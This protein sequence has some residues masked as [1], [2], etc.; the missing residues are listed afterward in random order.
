MALEDDIRAKAVNTFTDLW[1]QRTGIVVPDGRTITQGNDFIELPRATVAYADLDQ[2]TALVDAKPWWFAAEVY[3]TFLY[4]AARIFRAEGGTI[5]SYDGD[6]VMAI[7]LGAD[8]CVNAVKA[9]MKLNKAVK[10]VIQPAL[11]QRYADK[12]PYQIRHTVGIDV[13][14]IRAAQAGTRGDNDLVWVGRAANHAAKLNARSS[15]LA[16][17]VTRDVYVALD[18]STWY[19]NGI[20]TGTIMWMAHDAPEVPGGKAYGSNYHWVKI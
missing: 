8:Q 9:A 5:T 10:L 14:T 1:P 7:F 4:A 18:N 11:T 17:W 20:S 6:R 3:K 16:T 15:E 19:N 13:S 2:S 12:Y